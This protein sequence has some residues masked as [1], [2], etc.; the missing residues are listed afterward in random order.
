MSAKVGVLMPSQSL[1]YRWDSLQW[2][3]LVKKKH[4]YIHDE[5]NRLIDL[6]DIVF[7]YGFCKQWQHSSCNNNWNVSKVRCSIG[8]KNGRHF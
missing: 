2:H 8:V 3:T 4:I 6:F 7:K 5:F 1:A